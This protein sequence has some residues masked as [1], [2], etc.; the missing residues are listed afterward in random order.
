MGLTCDCLLDIGEHNAHGD[1]DRDQAQ[2]KVHGGCVMIM[3][4]GRC[5]VLHC[6][7]PSYSHIVNPIQSCPLL[8]C[9]LI[10][11]QFYH[12][13]KIS[14]WF[15]NHAACNITLMNKNLVSRV[16]RAAA[17]QVSTPPTPML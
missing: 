6:R 17:G 1:M 14:K 11:K 13:K 2:S 12:K 9:L 15:P 8:A 3:I 10:V 5:S 16:R 4:S 7:R